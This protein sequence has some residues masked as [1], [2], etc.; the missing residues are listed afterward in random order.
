MEQLSIQ[1]SPIIRNDEPS[2]PRSARSSA[3]S[4]R[5][6]VQQLVRG[7]SNIR[8]A[9][10]SENPSIIAENYQTGFNANMCDALIETGRE[11]QR[12]A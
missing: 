3:F 2:L 10:L 5:R 12:P 1:L 9:E 7:L 8:L 4:E 6:V 11:S